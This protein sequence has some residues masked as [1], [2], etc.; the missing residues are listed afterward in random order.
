MYREVFF[1]VLLCSSSSAFTSP[2]LLIFLEHGP[3]CPDRTKSD[4]VR[5]THQERRG[6]ENILER[7][8]CHRL[9]PAC[10]LISLSVIPYIALYLILY[11]ALHDVLFCCFP[12]GSLNHILD[13]FFFLHLSH[14]II[15]ESHLFIPF[16][17]IC[18][19]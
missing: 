18:L 5:F 6:P 3:I 4:M 11:S 19:D 13:N 17:F 8:N 16:I 14:S 2:S 9:S 7:I 1:L 15:F 10:Q 12:S